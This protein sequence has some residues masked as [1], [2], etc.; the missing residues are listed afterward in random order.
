MSIVLQ[1]HT[2]PPDTERIRLSDY[3]PKLFT[4]FIPSRKGIKKAIKRGAVHIDGVAGEC[5]RWVEPGQKIE[6]IDLERKAPKIFPLKLDVVFEDDHL[7]VVNK[8]AG[9]VVNGNQFRTLEN[10]LPFNLHPSTQK[11][12]LYKFRPVHRLD[13]LT[14]GLVLIAK[15]SL[16]C[17]GLGIQFEQKTIKKRYGAVVIGGTSSNGQIETPI[18]GKPALT[19]Y[20]M[21][22]KVPSLR[23]GYLT[24]LD[25]FPKTGRTHQ[26]RIHLSQLGFP[27][28][29][30]KIYGTEGEILKGKGMFLSAIELTFTHPIHKK[31]TKVETPAP[32]KFN[33][34]L[35]REEHRWRKYN[36]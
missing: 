12:A 27:I 19:T 7:A 33:K 10:A 26:I 22:R 1:S 28:L 21:L 35:D 30:D 5:G 14:S 20:Y 36:P 6:L 2:V 16:A 34:V 8:P 9:L 29:G 17:Q 18:E 11:D 25:V 31:I 32:A 24:L 15:T 13:S 23:N 3:A 4:T